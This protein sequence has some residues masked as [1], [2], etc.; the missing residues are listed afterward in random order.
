MALVVRKDWTNRGQRRYL[1]RKVYP[2]NT[3]TG[4][5]TWT[6]VRDDAEEFANTGAASTVLSHIYSD[7]V[8]VDRVKG[9]DVDYEVVA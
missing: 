5:W 7:Y 2:K 3:A 9:A 1:K 6:T 4:R 8:Y